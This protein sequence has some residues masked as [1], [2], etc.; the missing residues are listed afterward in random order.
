MITINIDNEVYE[1]VDCG[2]LNGSTPCASCDLGSN[3][4]DE[5][6]MK[7]YGEYAFNFPNTHALCRAIG[8]LTNSKRYSNF[9]KVNL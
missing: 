3:C 9:K 2:H 7:A 4:S 1:F 5:I 6:K 8:Q